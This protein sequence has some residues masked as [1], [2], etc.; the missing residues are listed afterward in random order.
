MDIS[1]IA[2]NV[3]FTQNALEESAK[4]FKNR[5]SGFQEA[6]SSQHWA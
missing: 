1:T 2:C 6:C 5:E 4:S 3:R